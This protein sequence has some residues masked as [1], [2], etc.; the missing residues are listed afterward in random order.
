MLTTL[1][2]P[3]SAQKSKD[4]AP[5][6]TVPAGNPGTPAA[7]PVKDSAVCKL[8]EKPASIKWVKTFKGRIDDVSLVDIVL[9]YDGQNCRGYMTYVKS[10]VRF[11]LH[12]TLDNEQLRLEERDPS[13]ALTGMIQGELKGRQLDAN[14]SNAANTLGSRLEA[15]EPQPGQTLS[16]GCAENKWANRYITRYNGARADMVL[17]RMHNGALDG[18]L[19]VEADAKTYTLRGELKADDTYELEALL[20]SGKTAGL[21]QGNLQNQQGTDCKWVGS[22]ERRTFNFTVKDKLQFG[23]F[24]YA[25]YRSSYD[26]IYPRSACANCNTWLD[27]QVT[28]WVN[29][30]KTTLAAQKDPLSPATRAS[31]RAGCW[32]DIVC[33]TENVFTGYL[34][35]TETWNED[36]QGKSFNF[37]L[38]SGKE[39]TFND[40]FNKSFNAKTWLENYA[41]KESPKLPQFASDPKYREWISKSGFPLYT[42]R[43]DG[44]ELSTLFHPVYGRQ[45][46]LVPYLDL[47][48]YMKKDNPVADF[49]K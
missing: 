26:A 41:K 48:P 40:L 21:L 43:R 9:G 6:S 32:A 30:C 36:A 3:L 22:G 28:A 5:K 19:W 18:F 34:T 24:D 23:C 25:D 7:A 4:S 1:A 33:W 10:H 38:R 17:I 15:E 13:N 44:L 49:V 27:Q 14:W 45:I 39:I 31:S 12:G 35:F 2:T 29:Q 42:L 16:T 46:L 47:K 20:P 11:R 8:F 37:D